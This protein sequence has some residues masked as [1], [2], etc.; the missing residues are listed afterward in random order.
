[1]KEHGSQDVCLNYTM[2]KPGRHHGCLIIA[3]SACLGK[4]G[5]AAK[6]RRIDTCATP[7]LHLMKHASSCIGQACAPAAGTFVSWDAYS[8]CPILCFEV[9]LFQI[10]FYC[11]PLCKVN[12]LD[13]VVIK[14]G[15][16]ARTSSMDSVIL[17]STS[18]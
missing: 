11:Q 9:Q 4:H 8:I 17:A 12:Y 13:C 14:S 18:I 10:R 5:R 15:S 2:W 16:T 7:A 3:S 6:Q 1:M